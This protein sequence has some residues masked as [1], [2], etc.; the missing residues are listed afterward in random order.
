MDY[1]MTGLNGRQTAIELRK[2]GF[3][4]SMIFCSI[5]EKHA[6]NGYDVGAIGYLVKNKFTNDEFETVFF[7]AM[8][9]YEKQN[10]ETLTF[11]YS[12]EK[13]IIEI[14]DILYFEV[15]QQ[16]VTVHYYVKSKVETFEFYSTLSD[17]YNKVKDKGFVQNHKSYIVAKEYIRDITY[18]ELKMANGDVLPVGRKYRDNCRS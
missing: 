6:I 3:A 10:E 16:I 1:Y 7:R 8:R 4:G 15:R 11:T 12:G 13:R 14:K 18:S 9:Y 17:I 2:S 5:D